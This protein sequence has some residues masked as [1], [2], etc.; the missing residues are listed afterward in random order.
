MRH[1][2]SKITLDRNAAQ[3]VPLLRNLAI[4]LIMH[5]KITTSDAKAKATRSFVER[6]ITAG[7]PNTLHAR[8]MLLSHLNNQ[9]AVEKLLTKLSPQFKDRRGGYI[10]SIKIGLRPGD[11]SKQV[12]LEFISDRV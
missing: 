5:E 4:S 1:R 9:Q 8:R 2:S 6:L 12:L 11:G 7:K 3:R 10:R